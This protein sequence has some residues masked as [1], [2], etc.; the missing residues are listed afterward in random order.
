MSIKT[1][2]D[3]SVRLPAETSVML[4]GDHGIGKSQVIRKLAKL[5]EAKEGINLP[6][7]DRRLSQM[8]EG[9]MVGLPSTDGAV[10]RFNPPDWYKRACLEPCLLFLD[11]LN[12]ATHEVMQAAFQIVLDRELNGHR[13]HPQTRVCSAVNVSASYTVNEIDPALLDRFWVVDLRPTVQDWTAWA[14]NP[15]EGNVIGEIVDWV[16]AQENWLDPPKNADLSSKHTSRRS[17]ERLSN[18]IRHAGYAEDLTNPIVYSISIGYV[19]VEAT[20]A[21]TDFVKTIDNR[22]DPKVLVN[23]YSKVK[24][25]VKRLDIGRLN[26]V[27]DRVVEYT[28]KDIKKLTEKHAKNIGEFLKDLPEEQRINAWTKL[29]VQGVDKL[30]A[31]RLIHKHCAEVVLDTFGIKLGAAGAGM[32]VNIPGFLTKKDDK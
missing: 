23:D 2:L 12:R 32:S 1:F 20:I 19:G 15:E 6:V 9:D 4:R 25:K 5:I 3:T 16:E 28:T 17:I 27:I 26:P 22:I 31:T 24:A 13:L 30:D 7:I 11:E 8:S 14:R 18:A 10:T 29:I 21:F